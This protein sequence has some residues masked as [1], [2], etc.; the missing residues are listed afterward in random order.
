MVRIILETFRC[1]VVANWYC[2]RHMDFNRLHWNKCKMNYAFPSFFLSWKKPGSLVK[3]NAHLGSH[4]IPWRMHSYVAKERYS[5]NVCRYYW[6]LNWD[7]PIIIQTGWPENRIFL[8]EV[9]PDLLD[10]VIVFVRLG[11]WFQEDAASVHFFIVGRNYMYR[12]FKPQ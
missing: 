3:G 9:L 6:W 10:I 7:I 2:R 12:T 5:V 4:N 8:D 1:L 11:I